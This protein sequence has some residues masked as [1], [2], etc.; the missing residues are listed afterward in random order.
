MIKNVRNFWYK[1]TDDQEYLR[2]K[3]SV[4]MIL[5][6]IGMALDSILKIN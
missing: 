4:G 5:I 6:I 1:F 3:L 2:F